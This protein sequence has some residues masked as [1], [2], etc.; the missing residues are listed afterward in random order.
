MSWRDF[1]GF[2]RMIT[3]FL[4]RLLFILGVVFTILGGLAGLCGTLFRAVSKGAWGV[5][6]ITLIAYPIGIL[7]MLLILR[8]Y[9]ELLMLAF[10]IYESL[11]NI[12]R[13]LRDKGASEPGD[14]T[15]M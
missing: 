4:I 6:F 9:A 10:R 7:F 1:F 15:A 3:P 13:M 12:E 2:E 8:V 11:N 5:A 14:S